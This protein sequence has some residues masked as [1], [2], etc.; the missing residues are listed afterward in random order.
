MSWVLRL[1]AWDFRCRAP[2]VALRSIEGLGLKALG[3]EPRVWDYL[4]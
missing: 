2:G 4:G 3:L 1:Q